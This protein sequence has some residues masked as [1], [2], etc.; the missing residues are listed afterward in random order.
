MDQ[1]TGMLQTAAQEAGRRGQ[2]LR[3]CAAD[4]EALPVVPASFDGVMANHVLYHLPDISRGVKELARILK[5]G[6]W[7][8]TTTNSEQIRV[9]LIDLHYQALEELGIPF[10]PEDPSPFSM[11]NGAAYLSAAFRRV[12]TFY[13]EDEAT[14][15]TA[16]D[17][18]AVYTTTGR[19][20]NI[21]Q[22][23]HIEPNLKQN[24][25]PTFERLAADII[26]QEGILRTPILMGAFVC[27]K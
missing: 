7:L 24:L 6:G 9:L 23:P 27:T 11:E 2:Q 10:I 5:P 20:R 26:H 12:E 18:V 22:D 13:F 25:R 3:L 17:F 14:Y 19:Y 21:Q 1:S 16:N 15:T 4:I 8:L